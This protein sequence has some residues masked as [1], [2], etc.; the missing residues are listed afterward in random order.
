[1]CKKEM[2]K[3]SESNEIMS[4]KY[5]FLA[6]VVEEVIK[7]FK[8]NEKSDLKRADVIEMLVKKFLKCKGD[9]TQEYQELF[10]RELVREFP[11]TDCAIF[12]QMVA[13]LTS[14]D[15]PSATSIVAAAI[16]GQ[17]AFDENTLYCTTC[18]EEG[19]LKKCSKCK[20]VQYCDREC[21]RLH[22]FLHKKSCNRHNQSS[23]AQNTIK[24]P[25][26]EQISN[27]VA[28]RLQNV[29]VN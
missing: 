19:P 12:R 2:T 9:G 23:G 26:S 8:R 4:F 24:E 5:H 11:F 16:N 18:S 22:W 27:A 1:M 7:T 10:L 29:T 25:D 21:Q 13:T 15:P 14:N 6:S 17:R 28:S 20:A 3:G